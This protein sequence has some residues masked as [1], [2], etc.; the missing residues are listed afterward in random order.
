MNFLRNLWRGQQRLDVAFW[1]S[2]LLGFVIS[3]SVAGL[4]SGLFTLLGQ[5]LLGLVLASIVVLLYC[6]TAT[7]GVWRSANRYPDTIWW[8]AFAKFAVIL[9]TPIYLLFVVRLFDPEFQIGL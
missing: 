9:M 8:P 4:V 3:A 5:R 2:Y 7:V 1:F 6:F